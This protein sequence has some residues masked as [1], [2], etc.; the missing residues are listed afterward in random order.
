MYMKKEY[1]CPICGRELIKS[2]TEG[3]SFQCLHCDEDFTEAEV[4]I[5]IK[6]E[7]TMKK[8]NNRQ[9]EE[10]AFLYGKKNANKP[11]YQTVHETHN[12]TVRECEYCGKPLT[13]SDV[14][15][16]GTLCETCYMKEYY[17]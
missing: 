4:T 13:R 12:E 11:M 9:R 15:D 2:E 16:Y 6:A 8:K 1:H 10:M 3:Y 17:G 14:N 7:E 5:T